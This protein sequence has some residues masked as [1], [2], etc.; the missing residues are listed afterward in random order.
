MSEDACGSVR[1]FQ[2]K[3][4]S[5]FNLMEEFNMTLNKYWTSLEVQKA[6]E[7]GRPWWLGIH[8]IFTVCLSQNVETA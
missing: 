4:H 5:N 8:I 2:I 3:Q 6:L 1:F 7:E